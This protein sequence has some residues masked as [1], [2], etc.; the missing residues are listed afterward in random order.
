[1]TVHTLN[2]AGELTGAIHSHTWYGNPLDRTPPACSPRG[3][4]MSVSMKAHGNVDHATRQIIFLP[5]APA[6]PS[7]AANPS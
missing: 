4:E 5:D 2:E 3:F 7:A 6:P 1:M